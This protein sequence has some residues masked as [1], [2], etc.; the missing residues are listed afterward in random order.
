[1]LIALVRATNPEKESVSDYGGVVGM[2]I[3]M[4]I[5]KNEPVLAGPPVPTGT[6]PGFAYLN[7]EPIYGLASPLTLLAAIL[8]RVRRKKKMEKQSV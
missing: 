4:W 3:A 6:A 2:L 8:C 7:N 5:D 1:M